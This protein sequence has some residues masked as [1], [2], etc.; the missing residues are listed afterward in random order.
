LVLLLTISIP[1]QALASPGKY[2][3]L[4]SGEQIPWAGWCFDSEA[5]SKI[6]IEKELQEEKCQLKLDKLREESKAL[7]DFNLEKLKA[8]M[9]FEIQTRQDSIV[10]LKKENLEFE[11]AMIHKQSYGWIAPASIG[12]AVGALSVFIISVSL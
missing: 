9:N 11:K 12:F 7:Y 10:A 4:E 5:M 3:T 2:V 1:S 6:L 8:E